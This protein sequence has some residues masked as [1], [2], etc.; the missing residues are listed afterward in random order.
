MDP[1]D[2]ISLKG[3][4]AF[5]FLFTIDLRLEHTMLSTRLKTLSQPSQSHNT[6]G[7][8]FASCLARSF[9]LEKPPPVAWGQPSWRQKKDF[10]CLLWCF[11][12]SQPRVKTALDVQPG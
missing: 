9:L 7:L 5:V 2:M 11:L 12:R 3:L 8:C 4:L 6:P 1:L 10:V